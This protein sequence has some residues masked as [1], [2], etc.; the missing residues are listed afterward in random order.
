MVQIQSAQVVKR[1]GFIKKYNIKNN[2]EV[3]AVAESRYVNRTSAPNVK[4]FIMYKGA[5]YYGS[6]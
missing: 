2:R 3:F 1:K 4:I 5:C 6:Y